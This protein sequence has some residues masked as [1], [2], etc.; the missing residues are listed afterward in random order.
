MNLGPGG[1]VQSILCLI[2]RQLKTAFEGRGTRGL[3]TSQSRVEEARPDLD[4][5]RLYAISRS[6]QVR[7]SRRRRVRACCCGKATRR[8]RSA[9][10]QAYEVRMVV[11]CSSPGSYEETWTGRGPQRRERG[12]RRVRRNNERGRCITC[13][14]LFLPSRTPSSGLQPLRTDEYLLLL[15]SNASRLF[16]QMEIPRS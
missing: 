5:V 7:N 1:I 6:R 9:R 10:I 15:L 12:G 4:R 14:S 8:Y 13:V 2:T 11:V 3:T 16:S